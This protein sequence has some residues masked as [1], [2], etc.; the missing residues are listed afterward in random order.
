MCGTFMS[1][2]MQKSQKDVGCLLVWFSAAFLRTGPLTEPE[3]YLS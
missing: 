2:C 3:V 1:T